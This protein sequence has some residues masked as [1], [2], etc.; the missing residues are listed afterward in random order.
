MADITNPTAIPVAKQDT[1]KAVLAKYG[2]SLA[3][4]VYPTEDDG[5]GNQVP[6]TSLTNGEAATVFEHMTRAYWRDQINAYE[7]NEAAS[8]ARQASLDSNTTD[9]WE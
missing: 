7:A 5:D 8:T 1:V 6:K 4:S 2:P 9:P 3:S